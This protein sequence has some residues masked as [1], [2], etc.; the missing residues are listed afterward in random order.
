MKHWCGSVVWV[1]DKGMAPSNCPD[2]DDDQN[3]ASAEQQASGSCDPHGTTC[4]RAAG[5]R[6]REAGAD[7]HG[8]APGQ[9]PT[10]DDVIEQCRERDA[11]VAALHSRPIAQRVRPDWLGPAGVARENVLARRRF[12]ASLLAPSGERALE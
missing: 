4:K 12:R 6:G 3:T 9:M 7:E 10:I 11:R 2:V 5:G 1:A 8:I